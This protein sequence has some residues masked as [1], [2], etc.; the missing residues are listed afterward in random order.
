[1]DEL[2]WAWDHIGGIASC[3]AV[4]AAIAS[5]VFWLWRSCVQGPIEA[6]TS[7]VMEITQKHDRA[8]TPAVNAIRKLEED[9]EGSGRKTEDLFEKVHLIMHQ[10]TERLYEHGIKIA[11]LQE[12]TRALFKEHE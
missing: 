7:S 11:A 4:V 8:I 6:L 12:R 2:K 3:V 1:M 5:F 9:L 10:H